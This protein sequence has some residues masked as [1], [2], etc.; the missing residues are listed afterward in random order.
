MVSDN[1]WSPELEELR[2]RTELAHAMGGDERVARQHAGGR[3]TVRERIERMVD[4]GSFQELGTIA[5]AAEYS[6]D[7]TLTRLTPSNCV[8]GRASLDGRTVIVEGDDFTVRGGSADAS[9]WNKMVVAET[10]AG[11][12]RLPIVRIIEGSGGGGSVRSIEKTGRSNLPN[13]VGLVTSVHLCAANLAKVP[14]VALGLGSVAGLGGVRLAESHYSIIVKDIS[15]VFVAGPP[16]VERLGEKV[17]KAELGGWETQATAGGVDHVAESE[18]DA[19][20]CARRFLSYMPSSVWD[21]APR[22]PTPDPI[23]REDPG[24]RT[25]IP[26]RKARAYNARRIVDAVV[27]HGSFF[28]M[29]RLYGRSII[30]GLARLDGWPV[31]LMAGDPAFAGG[32]WDVPACEK[33][34]RFVDMAET[35]HLP[36][37]HLVDC[38]GFRVGVAAEKSGL[39]RVGARLISAINQSTVPWCSVILRN[40]YGM[41][42]GAHQPHRRLCF[43]YAWPSASWGSLPLEGGVEA[44]YRAELDAAADRAAKLA[45]IETRLDA[46]KSPFRTAETFWVEEIIDPLRTRR[47]LCEFANLAAP[48]RTPGPVSFAIRP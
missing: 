29:G 32:T 27:D 24:L 26:R 37:V 48:L 31:A 34:V 4:P 41:G 47:L 23:D 19:F 33:I 17:T 16:V 21:V 38:P 43:R 28:E 18:D 13:G 9:I 3:L 22:V 11:E 15:F 30:T 1:G 45:E 12:Y 35:F 2:R 5:G 8:V 14:V 7:G 46:L 20:A 44:A 42:G 36:V 40:V 6:A 25:I 10:M 39:V